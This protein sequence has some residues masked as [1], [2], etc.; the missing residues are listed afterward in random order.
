MTDDERR[1]ARLLF[2]GEL[3][4]GELP[5]TAL[6]HR[7][8]RRAVRARPVPPRPQRLAEALALKR[9]VLRYERDILGRLA[10]ARRAALGDRG[11]GPPR[12]LVRMD[13]FPHARARDLPERY[14]TEAFRCFHEIM[15]SAGVPYLLAVLPRP[16]HSYLDPGADGDRPLTDDERAALAD[17]CTDGVEAA[18]HGLTHRTRDAAARRR[19]ELAGLDAA[20]LNALIDR[21]MAELAEANLEPR[22]FV[23]PFNRFDRGHYAVLAERFK[24]V[25]GGPESVAQF[26]FH[27]TPLWRG[28]AVYLPSYPPLY[29][30]AEAIEPA[31]HRVVAA[32]PGTWVPVTLHLG[33]EADEGWTALGRLAETM[34]P[35]ARP[36]SELLGAL[37]GT[38]I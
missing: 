16:C 36:W 5:P 10:A 17:A 20:G 23:P 38:R 22:V 1:S 37:D 6:E 2:A 3:A 29:G 15:R 28:N 4:G 21:G 18:L 14:G 32:Q 35:Y 30:T 27:A 31:L 19:S 9:G 8:V 34:A 11:A 25:C 13:E 24:V 12:L 33:W 26:G 7:E